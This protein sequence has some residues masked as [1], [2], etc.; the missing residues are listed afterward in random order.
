M[1]IYL[2]PSLEK[3][4]F[5]SRATTESKRADGFCTSVIERVKHLVETVVTQ[6]AQKMFA[7]LHDQFHSPKVTV[8]LEGSFT[9]TRLEVLSERG[10]QALYPPSRQ[11]R[12]SSMKRQNENSET[13]IR[14][15]IN[16]IHSIPLLLHA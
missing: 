4:R 2:S 8:R 7:I 10:I 16:A 5:F 11:G 6:R 3:Y 1:P 14:N 15:H 13:I 9:Y 12:L